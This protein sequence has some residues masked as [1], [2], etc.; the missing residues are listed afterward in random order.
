MAANETGFRESRLRAT[1]IRE[2][3]L[4]IEGT[5]LEPVLQDFV[6]ELERA[7]IQRL[8]PHFYLSLEWGVPFDSISIALPFYLAS[9][10]LIALQRERTG[11]VEGSTRAELLRYLRHEMGHVVN[12]AYKLYEDE[13]W[14]KQF[15]AMTQPY[16]DDYRPEPFSRRFVHH[17]PGWYAQKHPDEDWAETFAVWLTP[18]R[19][20]RREYADAPEALAKLEFCARKMIELRNRPPLVTAEDRDEDVDETSST[21]DEHY[22]SDPSDVVFPPGLDGS[23]RTIF[24]D[25]GVPESPGPSERMPAGPLVRRLAHELP[26]HVYRWTGHFPEKTHELLEHLARR[27][28]ALN[29]VYAA[30]READVAIALTALITALAMN[31]VHQGTYLP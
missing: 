27:T 25:Y 14:I 28:D 3:G 29:Q 31:H 18:G 1:P 20:W 23:L 9:L 4:R 30:D 8:R 15:G 6:A 13:G 11:H 7:G 26:A 17:L 19:D 2:L 12:Y 16:L 21:L 5:P 24:E 10:E 22:E